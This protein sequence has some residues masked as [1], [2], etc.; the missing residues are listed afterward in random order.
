MLTVEVLS[1]DMWE[2]KHGILLSSREVGGFGRAFLR[3]ALGAKDGKK[4]V[5]EKRDSLQNKP[6]GLHVKGFPF[7]GITL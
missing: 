7:L 6:A 2:E 5:S 3:G 1:R 4:V